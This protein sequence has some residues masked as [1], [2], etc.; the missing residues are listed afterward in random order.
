[1][2]NERDD[3]SQKSLV[4]MGSSL[5]AVGLILTI[6][7]FIVQVITV[8][9]QANSEVGESFLSRSLDIG[10]EGA[11]IGVQ[12]TYVGILIVLL[13]AI[14]LSVVYLSKKPWTRDLKNITLKNGDI[15]LNVTGIESFEKIT[16]VMTEFNK[17]QRKNDLQN[18][19][20]Q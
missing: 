4:L 2:A 8:T 20:S 18:D 10:G 9:Q 14:L 3:N 7:Q 12:T 5:V 17:F 16:E 1:L 11:S 13:G 19:D 6:I 15:E